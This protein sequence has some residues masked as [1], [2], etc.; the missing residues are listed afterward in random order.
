MRLISLW[1][2]LALFISAPFNTEAKPSTN[3]QVR[4]LNRTLHSAEIESVQIKRVG[5]EEQVVTNRYTLLGAGLHREVKGE[6]VEASSVVRLHRDGAIADQTKHKVKFLANINDWN[7]SIDLHTAEGKRFRSRPLGISYYDAAT[8]ESVLIAELKDSVGVLFP[9]SRIVYPAAF[10]D[11]KADIEYNNTSGGLQQNLIFRE[12][13]PAPAQFGLNDETVF[14][15]FLTEFFASPAP[16]KKTKN[17]NGVSDDRELDFGGASIGPG[18]S[19]MI[20][21]ENISF[22]VQKQWVKMEGRT[23]LI[24]EVPYSKI[25]ALLKKLPLPEQ[26]NNLKPNKVHRTASKKRLLPERQVATVNVSREIQVSS[27]AAPQKGF[28][29]DYS[30]VTGGLTNFVFKADQ[31]YLITN[32]VD[33]YGTTIFEGGTVV[34]Y[35][36]GAA[37]KIYGEVDCKTDAYRPAVFTAWQDDSVGQTV[38]GSTNNPT[39]SANYG[40]VFFENPSVE[41]KYLRIAYANW[42]IELDAS[43]G[44][45][46]H[47]QFLNCNIGIFSS[48]VDLQLKNNTA[49]P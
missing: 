30:L 29:I 17:K 9:P 23:F 1:C 20:G 5:N 4:V 36:N 11:L 15:Q 47:C 33:L 31:T 42:G 34:K 19:F 40:L 48:G 3:A 46:S 7:G 24:E 6:L 44:T 27:L 2:A 14:V 13:P 21:N 45:V 35:Y 41:L 18:K 8:G 39:I 38:A 49:I 28:V 22:S 10:T 12:C 16:N 26:A 32:H 43:S 37:L 25:A